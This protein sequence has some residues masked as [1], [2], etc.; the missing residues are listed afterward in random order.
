[1][2]DDCLRACRWC[3]VADNGPPLVCPVCGAAQEDGEG[4]CLT[5]MLREHRVVL[6]RPAAIVD[7]PRWDLTLPTPHTSHRLARDARKHACN[8]TVQTRNT[9]QLACLI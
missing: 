4:A 8:D 1:M 9:L 5:H 7:L 3:T 6:D 2:Y